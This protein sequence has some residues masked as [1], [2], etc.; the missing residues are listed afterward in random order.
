MDRSPQPIY[1]R[2]LRKKKRREEKKRQFGPVAGGEAQGRIVLLRSHVFLFPFASLAR[3]LGRPPPAYGQ[4][5]K[6]LVGPFAG[7]EHPPQPPGIPPLLFPFCCAKLPNWHPNPDL[8]Y[9]RICIRIWSN[10]KCIHACIM[11]IFF[12]RVY[13]HCVPALYFF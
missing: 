13:T 3:R 4:L 6:V 10:H 7:D 11:P 5:P 9:F 12:Y 8:S 1:L 2:Q